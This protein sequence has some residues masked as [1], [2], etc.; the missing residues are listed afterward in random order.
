MGKLS[1]AYNALAGDAPFL[2]TIGRLVIK[3]HLVSA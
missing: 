3:L 2:A 1:Y